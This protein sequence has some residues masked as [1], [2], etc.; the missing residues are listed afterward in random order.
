MV[1]RTNVINVTTGGKISESREGRRVV[2]DVGVGT[3]S[4]MAICNPNIVKKGKIFSFF[5]W[6]DDLVR[7]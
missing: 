1:S 6:M 2:S 5:M 3:A 7:T 4:Q